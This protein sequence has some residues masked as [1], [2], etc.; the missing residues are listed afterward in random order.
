MNDIAVMLIA[1]HSHAISM[2]SQSACVL[3]ADCDSHASQTGITF[4]TKTTNF[5]DVAQ[6]SNPGINN[7]GVA[8][9]INM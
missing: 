4:M 7:L 5:P 6:Y 9:S 8:F 1:W 3:H 2:T